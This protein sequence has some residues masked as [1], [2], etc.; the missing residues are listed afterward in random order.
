MKQIKFTAFSKIRSNRGFT[1][2]EVLIYTV[3]LAII[4]LVV[5][6]FINQLLGINETS[7]R[8]RESTDNARRVIDTVAQEVRHAES[9]YTPTSTLGSSPGQ[10][11]LETTRDV[12]TD[13]DTTFVDFYVDNQQLFMK[14]EGESAERITSEKVKVTNL[15]FTNY[16]GSTS[17]PAIRISVT[18]EYKDAISGPTNPVT[19]KTT[20]V[21]RS[22]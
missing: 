4:S 18:V 7:R 5:L 22:I 14:R 8:V 13:H 17:W 20:A 15:T 1:L 11:S 19:M 10:L 9:L 12:P 6:V 21:M 3:V 2:T 16:N